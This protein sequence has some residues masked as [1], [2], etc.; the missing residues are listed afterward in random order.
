MLF[1]QSYHTRVN[2]SPWCPPMHPLVVS[3]R[4]CCS[5]LA[6]PCPTIAQSVERW[7]RSDSITDLARKFCLAENS[8]ILPL[9]FPS[10]FLT[11]R[12]RAA[13]SFHGGWEEREERGQSQEAHGPSEGHRWK[14]ALKNNRRRENLLDQPQK[15]FIPPEGDCAPCN[16]SNWE[17]TRDLV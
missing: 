8:W 14:T 15:S 12:H 3:H 16:P 5:P 4:R 9:S 10:P 13:A 17:E 6:R 1:L 2:A 7:G 11:R